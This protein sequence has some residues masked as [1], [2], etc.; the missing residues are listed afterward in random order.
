[1]STIIQM[2]S[3]GEITTISISRKNHLR[4]MEIGKKGESFD[5]I[6]SRVLSHTTPKSEAQPVDAALTTK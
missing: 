4:L 5:G 1:M 2:K 6:L 3:T